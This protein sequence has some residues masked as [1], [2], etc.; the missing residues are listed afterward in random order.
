MASLIDETDKADY[1][2]ALIDVFDS[3]KRPFTVYLEA[4]KVIIN[5]NPNFSRF[6]L[7]NQNSLDVPVTPQPQTIYG[8]ILYDKKQQYPFMVGGDTQS[9]VKMADGDV[10]IK[11]SIDDAKTMMVSKQFQIDGFDFVVDTSPRPHGLFI[12]ALYT[13]YLQR[14]Q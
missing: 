5:T 3:F 12:P 13:F 2:Q 8:C 1:Q 14:A 10:R 6:N 11:V 7:S 9:K 4:Q